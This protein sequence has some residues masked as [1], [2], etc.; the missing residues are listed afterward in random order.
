MRGPLAFLIASALCACSLF[1]PKL[2][3]PALSIVNVELLKSDLW[4]QQLKVRMRV[5]NP[6]ERALPIKGLVYS[7]EVDGQELAH[8][9]SGASFVVPALGEAEFDMSVSA[10]M[11]GM[12]L[13]LLGR[14]GSPIDYHLSG[15][16]SLSEGLLQSIPFDEHGTFKLQ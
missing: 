13:K 10:N 8:G 4:H 16:V 12:L 2:Q 7:L 14:G 15:K 9:Q 3:P 6:N 5:Q 1:A 11:A